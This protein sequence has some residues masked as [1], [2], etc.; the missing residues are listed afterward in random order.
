MIKWVIL[1]F[2]FLAGAFGMIIFFKDDLAFSDIAYY[3]IVLLFAMALV[4]FF[5]KIIEESKIET[6]WNL[7]KLQVKATGGAGIFVVALVAG[8][9]FKPPPSQP[10]WDLVINVISKDKIIEEGKINIM[11]DKIPPL[12]SPV[13]NS[14]AVFS[15]IPSS[16]KGTAIMIRAVIPGFKNKID[17]IFIPKNQQPVTY[18]PEKDTIRIRVHGNVSYANGNVV[19]HAYLNFEDGLVTTFTDSAGNFNIVFDNVEEG[20]MKSL[21]VY[22]ND[23]LKYHE[24]IS[25]TSKASKNIIL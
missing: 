5:I 13:H 21:R 4:V 6:I 9:Y 2:S 24:P 20:E 19:A 18:Y 12:S 23:Q 22:V 16:V 10:S 7:D 14:R 8:F 17:T 25:I 1:F 3:G 11:G 15:P